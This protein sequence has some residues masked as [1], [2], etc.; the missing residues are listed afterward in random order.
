MIS[1]PSLNLAR[2]RA[3]PWSITSALRVSCAPLIPV[4]G[5]AQSAPVPPNI[6]AAMA[7]ALVVLAMPISPTHS[8]SMPGSTHIMP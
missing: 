3:R 7:E 2:W 4:P 1:S 5:P 6:A 8:R